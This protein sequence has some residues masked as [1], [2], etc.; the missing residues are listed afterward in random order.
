MRSFLGGS[1][2]KEST[3]NAGN[4]G[5][6]PGLGRFP[7]KGMATHSSILAWRSPCTE[8]PGCLQSMG[9]FSLS[10]FPPVSPLLKFLSIILKS[11]CP[12][13]C[14]LPAI[15]FPLDKHTDSGTK[16]APF[17]PIFILE[18]GSTLGINIIGPEIRLPV[19]L[20]CW[21]LRCLFWKVEE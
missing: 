13:I 5:L 8:K 15:W 3:C 19:S 16:Q 17:Q 10:F 7:G 9:S 6:I 2:G 1:D 14:L 21:L 11:F 18:R 20:K 4:L 12:K